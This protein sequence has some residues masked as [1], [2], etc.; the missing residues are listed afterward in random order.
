MPTL[1]ALSVAGVIHIP[2]MMTG[3][4]LAG[5]TPFTAAAYQVIIL[6]LLG[7]AACTSLHTLLPMQSY[8]L[9]NTFHDRLRPVSLL[10]SK[11][12]TRKPVND[13]FWKRWIRRWRQLGWKG[14]VFRPNRTSQAGS[15]A[16]RIGNDNNLE[17]PF[18]GEGVTLDKSRTLVRW[19]DYRPPSQS[20]L[21][22]AAAVQ[23]TPPL[24]S[25]TSISTTFDAQPVLDVQDLYV[26]RAQVQLSIQL[27]AGDRIGLRGNSGLGK[28]Q[29]LRTLAGLEPMLAASQKLY[30]V[31]GW[32]MPSWR[33]RIALVAQDGASNLSGT[34]QE[35]FRGVASYES[36]QVATAVFSENASGKA[37]TRTKDDRQQR[38]DE[39]Y[40][41][42]LSLA[43]EWGISP[44]LFQRPWSTLSGGQAQRI[45]LAIVLGSKPEVLLLDETFSALDEATTLKVEKSLKKLGIPLLLVSHSIDQLERFCDQVM[46]LVP[47]RPSTT[48]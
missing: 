20:V 23:P 10:L 41:Y 26:P 47:A 36:Q 25:K 40:Q 16:G 11:E 22:G 17:D 4:L 42:I 5:Q 14:A 19:I 33:Q 12:T 32:E 38:N 15:D 48:S 28:S 24:S 8:A 2:G 30:G 27:R 37:K 39:A 3:Q 13:M 1:N 44:T 18:L 6:L 21:G 29:I 7:T 34:P 31:D 35:F 9:I 46:E 45:V 43:A